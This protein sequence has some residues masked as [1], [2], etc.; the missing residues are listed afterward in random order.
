MIVGLG[1]E[2]DSKEFFRPTLSQFTKF[3]KSKYIARVL[4]FLSLSDRNIKPHFS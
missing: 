2:G 3:I 1:W 4:E